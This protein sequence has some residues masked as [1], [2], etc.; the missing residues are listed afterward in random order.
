MVTSRK[1]Q[2]YSRGNKKK[3]ANRS[4]IVAKL[5]ARKALKRHKKRK[6]GE[7]DKPKEKVK[8]DLLE[9]Y[10]VDLGPIGQTIYDWF[11]PSNPNIPKKRKEFLKKLQEEREFEKQK[12]PKVIEQTPEGVYNQ[13]LHRYVLHN[14]A[15]EPFVEIYKRLGFY[16]KITP[17]ILVR[18]VGAITGLFGINILKPNEFET[19][20]SIR[21]DV[22]CLRRIKFQVYSLLG[23]KLLRYTLMFL[24]RYIRLGIPTE[25]RNKFVSK[26]LRDKAI[27]AAATMTCNQ[28]DFCG[29]DDPLK[30]TYPERISFDSQ[31]Y[32]YSDEPFLYSSKKISTPWSPSKLVH[33]EVFRY[34]NKE[35]KSKLVLMAAA[36]YPKF[37]LQIVKNIAVM[38]GYPSER[39]LITSFCLKNQFFSKAAHSFVSKLE[40]EIESDKLLRDAASLYTKSTHESQASALKILATV[41]YVSGLIKRHLESGHKTM[42]VK[43]ARNVFMRVREEV[44]LLP[45]EMILWDVLRDLISRRVLNVPARIYRQVRTEFFSVANYLSHS[46][47]R[48]LEKRSVDTSILYYG[49]DKIPED[50][51]SISREERM[52]LAQKVGR[53]LKQI[54]LNSANKNNRTF[55]DVGLY[56]L[57]AMAATAGYKDLKNVI[58][59]VTMLSKPIVGKI[60]KKTRQPGPDFEHSPHLEFKDFKK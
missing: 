41:P 58:T 45:E 6:V 4:K 56:I 54:W 24:L 27:A 20:K 17:R 1:V 60:E 50:I 31:G 9:K 5:K 53:N 46:L 12:G 42:P 18:E 30:Q 59:L 40:E 25:I 55:E 36:L 29:S 34:L 35:S 48:E 3:I 49:I 13:L 39:Q 28:I 15:R 37:A 10:G 57:D 11:W 23:H 22:L 32:P 21:A 52:D 2:S 43:S 44:E 8:N 14:Y 51:K 38:A 19:G 16:M 33:K 47:K 26:L 7:K